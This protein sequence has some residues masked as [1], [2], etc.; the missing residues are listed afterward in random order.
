MAS[1]KQDEAMEH[2][3]EELHHALQMS[4]QDHGDTSVAPAGNMQQVSSPSLMYCQPPRLLCTYVCSMQ[5]NATPRHVLGDTSKMTIDTCQGQSE[6]VHGNT[7]Y[8]SS[9]GPTKLPWISFF[10]NN[11]CVFV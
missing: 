3:D 6:H 5:L 2:M 7:M 10:D 11:C 8:C 4:M 9:Q 1:A